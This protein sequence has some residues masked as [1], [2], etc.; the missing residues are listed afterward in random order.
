MHYFILMTGEYED[1]DPMIVSSNLNSFKIYVKSYIEN[2][3]AIGDSSSDY[4]YMPSDIT[5]VFSNI[6]GISK[7]CFPI[8]KYDYKTTDGFNKLF[9]DIKN[10]VEEK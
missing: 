3:C 9:E 8:W 10:Y 7:K 4:L 5:V 2:W 6:M 1:R